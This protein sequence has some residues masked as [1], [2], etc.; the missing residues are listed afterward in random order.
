MTRQY[1]DH[2]YRDFSCY[3]QQGGAMIKRKKA[4]NNFP[5]KLHKLLSDPN[6]SDIVT[7]M[8][9]GR[10][11]KILDK[12]RLLSIAIPA[13][14]GQTKFESF[15]RQ[16]SGWGFKRMH[17]LGADYSCYYNQIFLQ[18]LPQLTILMK[19]V[20]TRKGKPIP[21][22][23][24]EPNFYL[25]SRSHPLPSLI[26]STQ[27]S[28]VVPTTFR[29]SL[30]TGEPFAR[31]HAVLSHE[32]RQSQ[33]VQCGEQI[34]MTN[35]AVQARAEFSGPILPMSC[36][37]QIAGM[38][39]AQQYPLF[40]PD[41]SSV[42]V[43]IVGT[44]TVMPPAQDSSDYM[45][46]SSSAARME[47]PQNTY[48]TEKGHCPSF[49]QMPNTMSNTQP[50]VQGFS[51]PTMTTLLAYTPPVVAV[52]AP[53]STS[54]YRQPSNPVQYDPSQYQSSS[55]YP[56]HPA[57][58]IHSSIS[59]YGE[60]QYFDAMPFSSSHTE[61]TTLP[62][63]QDTKT[64]ARSASKTSWQQLFVGDDET[65]CDDQ[66]PHQMLSYSVATTLPS[67]TFPPSNANFKNAQISAHCCSPFSIQGNDNH[68]PTQRGAQQEKCEHEINSVTE[69]VQSCAGDHWQ[70]H[71]QK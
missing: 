26:S 18:G 60:Y 12:E 39:N 48:A 54:I 51:I 3:I 25:I 40:R 35:Q 19:R 31:T 37:Y 11:W 21:H 8:P 52:A 14:F 55:A 34:Q 50:A 58:S 45:Y 65:D 42:P 2:T 71:T 41:H 20:I 15:T 4:G 10:A 64:P 27:D 70:P 5:A 61:Q 33:W 17:S 69:I 9:H 24:G 30:N 13:Y 57:E 47:A 1:V 23:E 68:V 16:L 62:P 29:S 43:P 36:Q 38:N 49:G 28:T 7:W 67:V 46:H 44:D 63:V 53:G 66:P 22:P 6:N 59:A 56:S 32:G